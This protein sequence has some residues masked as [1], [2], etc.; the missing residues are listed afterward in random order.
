MLK[1]IR[2]F[3]NSNK[4]KGSIEMCWFSK[5]RLVKIVLNRYI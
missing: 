1:N 3:K 2:K 4:Y 5:Y